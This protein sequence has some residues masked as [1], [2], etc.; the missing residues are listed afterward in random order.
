MPDDLDAANSAF[1]MAGRADGEP[2]IIP[3]TRPKPQP[4]Q[5][6]ISY[7]PDI[8]RLLPQSPEAE[9]GLLSSFLL[10]PREVGSMCATKKIKSD[11]FHVP[12]HGMVYEVLL[13]LWNAG[14]P[15]DF[16]TIAQILRNRGQLDAVGG[17]PF[18]SG[19]FTF[20]P[21]AANAAYYL[22]IV[23]EKALARK[24]IAVGTEYASRPYDEQYGLV[25][26][27]DEFERDVM[28]IRRT[29]DRGGMSAREVAAQGVN[30][31]QRIIDL[32][33]KIGGISTGF[34]QLDR[35]TDGLNGSK[36]IG[37]C[38]HSG[39]GKS[40]IAMQI[41]EHVSLDQ[42][43]PVAAWPL[44]MGITQMGKRQILSRARVNAVEWR[45]GA[46]PKQ[47][48]Q[49]AIAKAAGEFATAKMFFQPKSDCTIQSI[50]TNA[51]FLVANKGIK[52][53]L[54]DSM[55]VLHSDSRQGRDNRVREVAECAEG[56]KDMANELGIW[57]MVIVH[58]DRKQNRSQRP[59]RWDVAESA[60][61]ERAFDD[62]WMIYEPGFD[63]N[64]T[65][66]ELYPRMGL[67]IPKQRDGEERVET[68][69]KFHKP[70]TRFYE[71]RQD[72]AQGEMQI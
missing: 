23:Q 44:E 64:A 38:G 20:L 62:L 49:E 10:A 4:L 7:L 8:Y 17:A 12:T 40:S 30:E 59:Q 41:L 48:E 28:A 71:I 27:L 11:V 18:V 29:E 26:L 2:D 61:V 6:K 68:F 66:P 3:I 56:F 54:V 5:S 22:E 69:F 43:I 15:I 63:E 9:Q 24:M 33:G 58:I 16:I 37:I 39:T 35:M 72:D 36:V 46:V 55:S 52:G 50:R 21:T 31:I 14:T 60:Q 65:E 32:G 45:S 34:H 47:I 13:E 25:A 70:H 19:L 53:I 1:E 51:R 57:I 67:Y 42:Q